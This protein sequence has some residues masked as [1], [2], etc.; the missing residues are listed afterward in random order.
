MNH[1][2][3]LAAVFAGVGYSV[4][5]IVD[6]IRIHIHRRRLQRFPRGTIIFR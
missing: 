6:H 4:A 1:Y 5:R 3:I 2:L